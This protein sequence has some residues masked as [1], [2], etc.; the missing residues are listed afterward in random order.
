[1]S[2]VWNATLDERYEVSV[3]NDAVLRVYDGH[4]EETI[5]E[6][7]D[8]FDYEPR[9]GPDVGD[10]NRWQEEVTNFIDNIYDPS[11]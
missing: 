3:D 2:D 1:M 6:K 8:R 11:S 7:K 10:L 9:F 5:F 4:I